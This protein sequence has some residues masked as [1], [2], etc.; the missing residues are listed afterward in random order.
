MFFLNRNVFDLCM[1]SLQYFCTDNISL[2]GKGR[3]QKTI[4]DICGSG[5][6]F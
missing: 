1:K 3:E 6:S 5:E 2:E 4:L